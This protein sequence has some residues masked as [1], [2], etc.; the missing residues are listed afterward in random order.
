MKSLKIIS[1]KAEF[2]MCPCPTQFQFVYFCILIIFN[3]IFSSGKCWNVDKRQENLLSIRSFSFCVNLCSG[4]CCHLS[5][6]LFY[7]MNLYSVVWYLSQQKKKKHRRNVPINLYGEVHKFRRKKNQQTNKQ[8][9]S[10]TKKNIFIH[11]LNFNI[12]TEWIYLWYSTQD[13]LFSYK[14]IWVIPRNLFRNQITIARR[15][16][17]HCSAINASKN[18][19]LF[20]FSCLIKYTWQ[21]D[22]EEYLSDSICFSVFSSTTN[23]ILVKW[24]RS[25]SKYSVEWTCL[26]RNTNLIWIKLVDFIKKHK[27]DLAYDTLTVVHK[28]HASQNNSSPLHISTIM[29]FPFKLIPC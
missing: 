13:C 7:W 22:V 23:I 10:H 29:E 6:I 4:S 25:T 27:Q 26:L 14:F 5:L 28:R 16:L 18:S 15:T 17:Y 9:S 1:S 21:T 11:F 8:K 12:P 20:S 3:T 2:L 24:P 19:C